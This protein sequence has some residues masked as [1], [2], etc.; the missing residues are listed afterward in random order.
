MHKQQ[1][2]SAWCTSC[3][4]VCL[5]YSFGEAVKR[6]ALQITNFELRENSSLNTGKPGSNRGLL[7]WPIKLQLKLT[8]ISFFSNTTGNSSYFRSGYFQFLCCYSRRREYVQGSVWAWFFMLLMHT[9]ISYGLHP[10]QPPFPH[11]STPKAYE[12]S[13]GAIFKGR[14]T[15]GE[16]VKQYLIF[17][18]CVSDH[19]LAR[20]CSP[21]PH[22]RKKTL[23]WVKKRHTVLWHA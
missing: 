6:S 18:Y 23:H 19:S 8:M 3:S 22:F 16:R 5:L 7:S 2:A 15:V 12:D 1:W 9:T 10:K 20:L 14:V 4:L 11:I 13:T 17:C 21:S